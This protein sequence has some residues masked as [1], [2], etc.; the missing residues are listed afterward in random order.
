TIRL[1]PIYPVWCPPAPPRSSAGRDA[2]TDRPDR[3]E[4]H[5]YH[6]AGSF[7]VAL[8]H[9]LPNRGDAPMSEDSKRDRRRFLGIAAS[10]LA[11]AL[12]GALAWAH[13]AGESR[14]VWLR[15]ARRAV[16]GRHRWPEEEA[17]PASEEDDIARHR[18][19][20]SVSLR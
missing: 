3:A 20:K 17:V 14:R 6:P 2:G 7:E 16:R 19:A 8:P 1:Q 12:V 18:P 10:I 13:T 4:G 15:G 5:R 9:R 11:A